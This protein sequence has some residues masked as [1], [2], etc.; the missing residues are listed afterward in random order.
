MAKSMA[1]SSE[2]R[3]GAWAYTTPSAAN[4]N[5]IAVIASLWCR[6]FPSNECPPFVTQSSEY[7]PNSDLRSEL[8]AAIRCSSSAPGP[9]GTGK[10]VTRAAWTGE[11]LP[12]W[13]RPNLKREHLQGGIKGLPDGAA[14][15]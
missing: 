15:T 10:G 11:S 5:R 7:G 4:E 8:R 9:T 14:D 13:R 1:W 3:V 12:G 2:I 6:I